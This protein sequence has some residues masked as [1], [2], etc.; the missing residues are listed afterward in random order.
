M[1]LPDDMK[2]KANC[3]DLP[4]QGILDHRE[5]RHSFGLAS[6][7]TAVTKCRVGNGVCRTFSGMPLAMVPPCCEGHVASTVPTSKTAHFAQ[8]ATTNLIHIAMPVRLL[9]KFI[10]SWSSPTLKSRY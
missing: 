10:C 6:I 9:E 7:P 2:T 4:D 5:T 8:H 1:T 3:L